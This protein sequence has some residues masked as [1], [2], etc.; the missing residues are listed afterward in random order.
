MITPPPTA[1][2]TLAITAINK[3]ASQFLNL[4]FI[5]DTK[6]AKT[7]LT[8]TYRACSSDPNTS[9]VSYSCWHGEFRLSLVANVG[10]WKLTGI[11]YISNLG[12]SRKTSMKI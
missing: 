5:E 2:P 11:K 12:G 4:Q 6:K 9:I 3:G 10:F 7:G 1:N 8:E